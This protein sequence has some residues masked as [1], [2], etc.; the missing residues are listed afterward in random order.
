MKQ[1]MRHSR[2]P[3]AASL[4]I[5]LALSLFDEDTRTERSR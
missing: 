2:Y 1:P 5:G 3:L 4:D